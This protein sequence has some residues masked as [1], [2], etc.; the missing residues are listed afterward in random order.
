MIKARKSHD[1]K[2][3]RKEMIM[4]ENKTILYAGSISAGKG[5]PAASVTGSGE[6]IYTL[7]LSSDGVLSKIASIPGENAGIIAEW[8]GKYIYAANEVKD[9]TGLNGS[10][11]GVSAYRIEEDGTLSFLNDSISYGARTSYVSVSKSGK[12]LL[13]SNHGSHSTVTCHYVQDENGKW[14]LQR[15]FDDSSVAV[16]ALKEDGSIGELTDLK[17]F[18]GKGYWCHGGGQ[19][20]SHLHCVKIRNDLVIACNR[21]CDC[22]EVMRLDEETGTLTVLER[23]ETAPGLAPRHAVFHPDRN[24][25]Y[26]VN[27]NY[28][29]VSVFVINEETGLLSHRQTAKVMEDAYYAERPLPAFTKR[30]ADPEEKNS[31]GF[32]DRGAVMCSDIHISSDG[33]HLYVSNRCFAKQGSLSVLDVKEDGM[34]VLKQVYPLEGKDPRGFNVNQEGTLLFVSLLDQNL[35]QVFELDDSGV[36]AKKKG[37]LQISSPGAILP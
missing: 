29:C 8:N 17:V 23:F 30:H 35:I 22:L 6:G 19:S 18:K 5:K 10:G 15:G 24:F 28:P 14:V 2:S 25:L 27:E 26:I 3:H 37:E 16:F 20:T 36:I 1:I 9:F 4:A 7:A 12:Y 31:S 32:G 21:G 33:R 34:L 11:G 13:A